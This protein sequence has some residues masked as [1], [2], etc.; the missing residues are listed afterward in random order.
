MF[1]V[2]GSKYSWTHIGLSAAIASLG[3]AVLFSVLEGVI[4][5]PFSY[6]LPNPAMIMMFAVWCQDFR[7]LAEQLILAGALVFVAGKFF[8]GRTILTIGFDQLDT[9]RVLP[10]GPDEENVVWI[11][12]R[13]ATEI[14][15]EAIAE[16]F[17]SRLKQ[18]EA[19]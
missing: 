7:Y 11:G 19:T 6:P 3:F 1:I 18:S 13:Y 17:K 8:E 2:S 5:G 4:R 16:A 10:K 15:A 12:H 14:E 9:Q